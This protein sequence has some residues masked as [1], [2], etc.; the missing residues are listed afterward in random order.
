MSQF[1]GCIV[2][3]NVQF[4]PQ[5]EVLDDRQICEGKVSKKKVQWKFA[6]KRNKA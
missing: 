4:V 6:K 5:P 2:L 1:Y 3:D